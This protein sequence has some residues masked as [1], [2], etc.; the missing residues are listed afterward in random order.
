MDIL[1]TLAN[2]VELMAYISEKKYEAIPKYKEETAKLLYEQ[3]ND[4]GKIVG[5]TGLDKY[6]ILW[7]LHKEELLEFEKIMGRRV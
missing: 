5:L 4:Y 1:F 6:D 2:I 3:G 7:V